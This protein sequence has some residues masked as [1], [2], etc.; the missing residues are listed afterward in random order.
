MKTS[1]YD[2]LV[3]KFKEIPRAMA[4]KAKTTAEI[5]AKKKALRCAWA[6]LIDEFI[7]IEMPERM[8]FLNVRFGFLNPLAEAKLKVF[9][10]TFS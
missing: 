4:M 6:D 10:G 7:R 5:K 2:A 8:E 1:D 3:S 9:D